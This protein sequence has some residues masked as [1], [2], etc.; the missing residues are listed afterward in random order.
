MKIHP[1]LWLLA[2]SLTACG[3]PAK[4]LEESKVTTG[5]SSVCPEIDGRF[6]KTKDEETLQIF[7]IRKKAGENSYSLN[8]GESFLI[9]DGVEKN[10]ED[11]TGKG[12]YS[13]T[14]TNNSLVF[15]AQQEGA[16]PIHVTYTLV[17][18]NEL[19]VVGSGETDGDLYI[20]E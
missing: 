16:E 20:R 8:G 3:N 4:K 7:E 5:N 13:L 12:H 2:L 10:A 11:H 17:S 18:P 14:C 15:Q 1:A 9:A 6:L 19:K